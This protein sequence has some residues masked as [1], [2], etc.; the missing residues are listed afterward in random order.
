[1]S[2]KIQY[3]SDLHLEFKENEDFLRQN[4]IQ[5]IGEVLIL[6]GDILPIALQHKFNWFFDYLSDNFQHTY[7]VPS[8]DWQP[9]KKTGQNQPSGRQES[10]MSNNK[11]KIN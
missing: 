9:L 5:P 7:C 1:M 10:L 4:P 8:G 11:L 3:C 2:L 6:A